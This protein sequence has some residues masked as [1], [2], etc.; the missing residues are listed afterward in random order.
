MVVGSIPTGELGLEVLEGVKL[1]CSVE[2]FVILSMAA[3]HL[4]VVPGGVRADELVTDAQLTQRRL[5]ERLF[6]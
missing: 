2:A 3:L 4:A 5:K 1:V 6:L